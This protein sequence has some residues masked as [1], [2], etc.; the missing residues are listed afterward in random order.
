[1]SILSCVGLSMKY[2]D[3]IMSIIQC[4]LQDIN[5]I[6]ISKQIICDLEGEKPLNS[7]K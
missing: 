6:S 7:L 4:G 3:S 5:S 2:G 1:M